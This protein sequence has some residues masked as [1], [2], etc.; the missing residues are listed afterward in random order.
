MLFDPM[1]LCNLN[2][3]METST[4]GA[5]LHPTGYELRAV[6]QP[7]NEHG[8]VGD[9]RGKAAPRAPT[10]GPEAASG[11]ASLL[12]TALRDASRLAGDEVASGQADAMQPKDE[13][14]TCPPHSTA[15]DCRPAASAQ[16]LSI[17]S[18]MPD[19]RA[20]AKS[21]VVSSPGRRFEKER[22]PKR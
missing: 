21:S 2:M 19:R 4:N 1:E 18:D 6:P 20:A 12:Q 15:D 13:S 17:L 22:Q 14:D 10:H 8:V 3:S 5:S 16:V 9:S 7:D 11:A